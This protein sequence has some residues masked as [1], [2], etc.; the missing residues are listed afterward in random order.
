MKWGSAGNWDWRCKCIASVGKVYSV[1]TTEYVIHPPVKLRK[2][3]CPIIFLISLWLH[4][5]RFPL[6]HELVLKGDFAHVIVEAS[7]LELAHLNITTTNK[8]L[9]LTYDTLCTCTHAF[10]LYSYTVFRYM[11]GRL[12]KKKQ[13]NR[14]HMP[15]TQKTDVQIMYE[16][17]FFRNYKIAK[18]G[19]SI[20]SSMPGFLHKSGLYC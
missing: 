14:K 1:Y 4:S 8:T 16:A 5:E 15:N 3:R 2:Q 18:R 13:E 11:Y 7:H 17:V 12:Y 6:G 9:S 20:K 19:S 10:F